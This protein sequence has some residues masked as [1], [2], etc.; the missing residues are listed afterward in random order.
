MHREADVLQDRIEIAALRGSLCDAGER[1]GSH[2]NEQIER[3]RDPGLNGEHVGFQRRRQVRS[4]QRDQR[5]EQRED[6][7][8]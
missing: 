4:E 5:A 7:H 8:P 6:Q 2:Q 1:I 3:S